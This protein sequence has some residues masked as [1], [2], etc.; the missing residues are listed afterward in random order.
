VWITVSRSSLHNKWYHE[1]NKPQFSVSS[2][3]NRFWTTVTTLVLD[4]PPRNTIFS[5]CFLRLFLL[6]TSNRFT[7]IRFYFF[8][9]FPFLLF[10]FM[11]ENHHFQQPVIPKFDGFY[12]H[13]AMLMENL[14]RSKEYWNSIKKWCY[15]NTT[16]CHSWTYSSC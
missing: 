16:K 5:D 2:R 7:P 14:L 15:Y 8:L 4:Q 1:P 6:Q 3:C 10:F 11:A 12:E 13:W 9:L